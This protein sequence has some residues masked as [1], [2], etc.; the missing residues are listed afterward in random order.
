MEYKLDPKTNPQHPEEDPKWYAAPVP[1]EKISTEEVAHEISERTTISPADTGAVL[2][3]LAGLLPEY[4]VKGSSVHLQGIGTFRLGISSTGVANP[5]DFN[6]SHITGTHMIHTSDVRILKAVAANI[7][8]TDS[9]LRGSDS[10]S[11]NW[12]ADLVSGTAN[13]ALT[14]GGSV[15]LSGIKMK[16]EGNDPAVGLKLLHVETQQE[17]VVPLHSIP[18]NKA[19]EIVF[20][21]PLNLEPGHYQVRIVTQFSGATARTV[22]TPHSFTY[23]PLLGLSGT[24]SP[25]IN[26]PPPFGE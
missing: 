11:I 14:P 8:Y 6:R 7:H 5:N 19:K 13:E 2:E 22:K 17:T 25:D 23:E 12:L 16:I 1:A 24:Q 26:N 15:R 3:A 4:L 10:V 18:V 21:V 9:G 20:V